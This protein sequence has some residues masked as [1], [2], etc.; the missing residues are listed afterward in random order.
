MFICYLN[1]IKFQYMSMLSQSESSDHKI[2]NYDQKK[3]IVYKIEK[4]SKKKDYFKL[5]KLLS[6]NNVKFTMNSNGIFFNINKLPDLLLGEIDAFLNKLHEKYK[7]IEDSDNSN[8]DSESIMSL[9]DDNNYSI[10]LNNK[11]DNIKIKKKILIE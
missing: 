3:K 7:L 10:D 2:Y 6:K 8:N 9:D 4:I 1:F 11:S 5:Y